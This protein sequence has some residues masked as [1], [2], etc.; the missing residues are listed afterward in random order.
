MRIKY[1]SLLLTVFF[2]T[3]H[4][5]ILA[6]SS[7]LK[8]ENIVD[9]H[10]N[11]RNS[12]YIIEQI[13]RRGIDFET[14]SAVL[15][16]MVNE[17]VSGSVIE[18]LL[19]QDR[20]RYRESIRFSESGP[21]QPG[22]TIITDPPGLS[23]FIN[24]KSQGVT[25]GF[26]NTLTKGKHIIKVEHPLFFT[27]QE[28][29]DFDGQDNVVLRWRMEPREPVI[30]VGIGIERAPDDEP[31]SW[32]LRPRN[33]CP[34]CNVTL[35]LQSWK[36]FARAGE[37]IFVLTD[38][39]RRFFKG[40]GVTCLE[41]NLWRGEVRRDLPFRRLPPPTLRYFISDIRINGIELVDIDVNVNLKSIEHAIPDVTLDGDTGFLISETDA[42][43]MDEKVP[44]SGR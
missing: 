37:A 36:A 41:M 22:L 27:R 10:K 12:E 4:F 33:H 11:G 39:A 14:T 13:V 21:A 35:E 9:M 15:I 43:K 17:G 25:P 30:R 24:E 23:L 7:R 28:E 42:V 8:Q 20:T 1:F 16:E 5:T 38:E 18:V 44:G 19:G 26:S 34:G 31:W 2:L 32:I 40:T 3:A 6:E 29:I